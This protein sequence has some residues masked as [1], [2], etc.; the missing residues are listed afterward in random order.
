[1]IIMSQAALHIAVLW[2]A[3]ALAKEAMGPKALEELVVF[4][5]RARNDLRD[6]PLRY[7]LKQ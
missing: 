5:E 7:I 4:Q 2:Q 6:F 1:M 3:V